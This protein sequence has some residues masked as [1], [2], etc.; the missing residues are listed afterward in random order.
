MMRGLYAAAAGML[1]SFNRQ[2]TINNNLANVNTPGF[3]R[4]V[5]YQSLTTICRVGVA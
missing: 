1:A 2:E 4:D 3:K 5:Y